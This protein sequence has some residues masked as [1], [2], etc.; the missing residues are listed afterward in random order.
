MPVPVDDDISLPYQ[1]RYIYLISGWHNDGNVN[2][3]QLYDTKTNQ[4]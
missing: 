4:C 3:V 1:S 2:L